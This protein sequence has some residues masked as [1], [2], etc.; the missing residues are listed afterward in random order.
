MFRHRR[1]SVFLWLFSGRRVKS[2]PFDADERRLRRPQHQRPDGLPVPAALDRVLLLHHVAREGEDPGI[3]PA[4]SIS[5]A[6][7]SEV[8]R[9]ETLLLYQRQ[10]LR[11]LEHVPLPVVVH[12]PVLPRE[13]PVRVL[14]LAKRRRHYLARAGRALRGIHETAPAPHLEHADLAEGVLCFQAADESLEVAQR[15]SEDRAREGALGQPVLHLVGE[16][17]RNVR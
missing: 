5:S 17:R 15:V 16:A 11:D 10:R 12:L 13:E 2:N 8:P 9:G 14:T 3:I 1:D 6:S 4:S 7:S